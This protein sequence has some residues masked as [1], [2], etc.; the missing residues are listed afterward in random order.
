MPESY[1]YSSVL[2]VHKLVSFGSVLLQHRHLK[3]NPRNALKCML[4]FC[5]NV[6]VSYSRYTQMISRIFEN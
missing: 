2:T 6:L 1:S 4:W 5:G 3:K